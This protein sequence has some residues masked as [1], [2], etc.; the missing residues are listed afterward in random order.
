[1]KRFTYSISILAMTAALSAC[2]AMDESMA[3]AEPMDDS[4]MQSDAMSD[5]AMMAKSDPREG[6]GAG[7]FDAEQAIWNLELAHQL[8][9]PEGFHNPALFQP[10]PNAEPDAPIIAPIIL[11]NTD[12]AFSGNKIFVGN[13]NGFNVYE[14]DASG[15][16]EHILSVVCPGGQGDV[17]VFG[18]LL[19]RSVEANTGRL[20]CAGGGV[21]G[22]VSDERFRGVQV[23]DI[24][25]IMA[26]Q[27][28]AAVQTC[29]GSHTHTMVPP[30][31]GGDAVYV[32]NSGTADVRSGDELDIC[33]DGSPME[34]RVTR[35]T[36]FV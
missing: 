15:A 8:P 22:D 3:D 29:R 23:Y 25:D 20:D 5:D 9:P 7:V 31:D 18:D 4:A 17:S 36:A 19:F 10:N 27:L 11:A 24:S 2:A 14:L 30:K 32:Y 1:M 21:E 28:V 6:L 33:S 34:T 12:P 26:P 16:P 13:F 35:L